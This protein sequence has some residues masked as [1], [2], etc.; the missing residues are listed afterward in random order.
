MN[1]IRKNIKGYLANIQPYMISRFPS[2]E[3]SD[4]ILCVLDN[5]YRISLYI[6]LN[7]QKGNELIVSFRENNKRGIAKENN[8]IINYSAVQREIVPVIGEPT[9][10]RI[11]GSPMEEIKVFVQR[12]MLLLPIRVMAEACEGNIYLV[13]RGSIETPIIEECNQ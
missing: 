8:T 4:T 1:S 10:A 12:G 7:K 3:K 5:A 13:E 6:K 2:Q 9:G 11:E